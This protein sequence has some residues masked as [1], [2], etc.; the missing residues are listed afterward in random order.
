MLT[1]YWSPSVVAASPAALQARG[2]PALLVGGRLEMT[3]GVINILAEK[4]EP[5]PI[6]ADLRSRDFR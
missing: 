2:A 3:E 6:G 4:F 5:L 1:G